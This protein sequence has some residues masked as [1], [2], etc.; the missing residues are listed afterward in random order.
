[1][2]G[3]HQG[4]PTKRG[5]DTRLIQSFYS[6][7]P[8]PAE[9]RGARADIRGEARLH[10]VHSERRIGFK[11]LLRPLLLLHCWLIAIA[12]DAGEVCGGESSRFNIRSG[13]SPA[14]MLFRRMSLELR[15]R[16]LRTREPGI[17]KVVRTLSWWERYKYCTS[18]ASS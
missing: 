15:P 13:T 1:M 6:P 4:P 3:W 2:S 11:A 10:M 18:L 7:N 5:K 9:T 14:G 8:S 17:A 16:L 12:F